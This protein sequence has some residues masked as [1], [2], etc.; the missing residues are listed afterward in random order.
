MSRPCYVSSKVR[1]SAAGKKQVMLVTCWWEAESSC[2]SLSH[3]CMAQVQGHTHSLGVWVVKDTPWMFVW[4][5]EPWLSLSVHSPSSFQ[6]PCSRL[7]HTGH[8]KVNVTSLQQTQGCTGMYYTPAALYMGPESALVKAGHLLRIHT[9][10]KQD[11]S[12]MGSGARMQY[13]TQG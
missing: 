5:I 11:V 7:F 2:S 13:W 6:Q 12:E 10:L 4:C 3:W 9:D 1:A 8:S